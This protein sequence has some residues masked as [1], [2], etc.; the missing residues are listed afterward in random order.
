MENLITLCNPCH[1][2][3]EL[4]EFRSLAEILNSADDSPIETKEKGYTKLKKKDRSDW[5]LWVYGG[6]TRPRQKRPKKTNGIR[7]KFIEEFLANLNHEPKD[8]DN[9]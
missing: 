4:M 9:L 5:H 8:R 2:Y 7:E 3:V 6:V 1:D